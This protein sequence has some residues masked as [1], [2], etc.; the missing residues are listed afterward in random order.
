MVSL[1]MNLKF[2]GSL[3]RLRNIGFQFYNR[4]EDIGGI[5]LN[6]ILTDFTV[7]KAVS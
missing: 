7:P 4:F 3:R 1:M 2:G 6:S 5:I